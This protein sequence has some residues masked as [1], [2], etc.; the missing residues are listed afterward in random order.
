MMMSCIWFCDGADDRQVVE[1]DV[2]NERCNLSRHGRRREV[3]V[4]LAVLALVDVVNF[5][6]KETLDD[7]R[8]PGRIDDRTIGEALYNRKASAP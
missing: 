7:R 6:R 5:S 4:P 2:A 1:R 3:G 8:A